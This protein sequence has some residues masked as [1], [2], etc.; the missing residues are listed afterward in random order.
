MG[1]VLVAGQGDP[2]IKNITQKYQ[3]L[4]ISFQGLQHPEKGC[5]VSGSFANVGV[6]NDDHN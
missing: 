1:L 4:M 2:Q 3:I 5:M 6:G